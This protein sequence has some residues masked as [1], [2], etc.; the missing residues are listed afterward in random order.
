MAVSDPSAPS[1][2][3]ARFAALVPSG[4]TIL[5]VAAGAGRH[6]RFF[7]ERGHHVVA[8]DRDLS[9]LAGAA[10]GQRIELVPRDMEALGWPFGARQF[11]GVVVTNYLW[12][13]LLPAIVAAVAPGGVLLYETFAVG[14]ERYGRPRN[15]N[16]LL[17]AGELLDAVHGHLTVVAY[18]HGTTKR[19]A[20]IQRIAAVHGALGDLP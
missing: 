10:Q 20:V 4:G 19:P 11:A 7:L 2:W 5:D 9:G 16:F 6:T 3:I 12:R 8:M 14:N 13:P 17:R 15:P 18:E 1:P